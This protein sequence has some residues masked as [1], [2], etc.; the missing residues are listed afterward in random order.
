[1][2]TVQDISRPMQAIAWGVAVILVVIAAFIS[3]PVETIDF[4]LNLKIFLTGAASVG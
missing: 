4:I 2:P 1:L 3:Y